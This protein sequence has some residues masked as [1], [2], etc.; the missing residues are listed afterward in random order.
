MVLS[1]RLKAFFPVYLRLSLFYV[2]L[3]EDHCSCKGGFKQLTKGKLVARL[4]STVNLE[5]FA[6]ILFSA[7]SVKRHICDVKISRLGHNL[8]ISVNDRVIWLL[9]K[10]LF[11]RNF[12]HA[13]FRENKIPTKFPNLQYI[14]MTK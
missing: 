9:Q 11:L 10:V 2:I 6:R 1:R 3:R 5:I 4:L 12:S 14:D 13:K 7:K 8:P